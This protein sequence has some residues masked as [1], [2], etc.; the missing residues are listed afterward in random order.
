MSKDEIK[1]RFK[2]T[3]LGKKIY[4][5]FSTDLWEQKARKKAK[6]QPAIVQISCIISERFP[7][8]ECKNP[9]FYPKP[10]V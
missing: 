3:K 4:K 1:N 6:E 2:Q 7:K 9:F 5:K 10:A 8:Q